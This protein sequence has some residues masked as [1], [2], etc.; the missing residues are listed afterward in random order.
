MSKSWHSK[1]RKSG[2]PSEKWQKL[3]G[4]INYPAPCPTIQKIRPS[5]AFRK[6]EAT[7]QAKGRLGVGVHVASYWSE[8]GMLLGGCQ[9]SHGLF[10]TFRPIRFPDVGSHKHSRPWQTSTQREAWTSI[11]TVLR[12]DVFFKPQGEEMTTCNYTG[13]PNASKRYLYLD[14]LSQ[15]AFEKHTK[16]KS[17]SLCTLKNTQK[18]MGPRGFGPTGTKKH[19]FCAHRFDEAGGQ[20]GW[21][22]GGATRAGS[23]GL[24]LS[25]IFLQNP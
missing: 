11:K 4:S 18:T 17:K 7:G 2:N 3:L 15:P 16:N 25:R 20:G 9:R 5:E 14:S 21:L 23:G 22:A 6:C 1:P 24:G 8:V 10:E 13:W 12:K 19:P